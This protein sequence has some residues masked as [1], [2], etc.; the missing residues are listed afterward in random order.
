M[1]KLSQIS[2]FVL[3]LGSTAFAQLTGTKTIPGSYPTLE[4]A[5]AALNANGVG[6]GGVTFSVAA[7]Y[8]ETFTSLSSG[9][10]AT[11]T[12]SAASPIVFTRSSGT[13]PNPLITAAEGTVSPAEYVICL[14][15][16]DYVTIDGIDVTDAT[17]TVE[18]GYALLKTSANDGA[19]HN[20]IRNCNITMVKD[21]MASA[22]IFSGNFTPDD[23]ATPL[24]I[25]KLPGTNSGNRFYGNT[26]SNCYN[27]IVI[28]GYEDLVPPYGLYDQDN[29]IGTDGANFISNFGG[30]SDANNGIYTAF[31]N[32]Q[33][34]ANNSIS[35]PSEGSG[36]CAGIQV[37]TANDA[38]LDLYNNTISIEY[39]GTGAFYGIRDVHGNTYSGQTV[40]NVYNNTVSNCS[41][42]TAV[43]ASC[44]YLYL[45]GGGATCNV[46]DNIVTNNIYG[47][48]TGAAGSLYGI[49]F[50]GDQDN[51]GNVL[52]RANQ[53]T[54]I[55]RAQISPAGG[56][57]VYMWV[58]GG[59]SQSDISN[60]TVD[61]NIVAS[62][63]SC[64]G[65]YILNNPTGPKKVY[66]NT[67]TNLFDAN[68]SVVYG[69]YTGNGF[70][71]SVYNNKIQNINASGLSSVVYGLDL[72][73][74]SVGSLFDM[75]CY[76]N[77]VG[78][79]KSTAVTGT[80]SIYGI[81][82]LATN[83]RN[84]GVYNN[85][86]FLNASSSGST[87]GTVGLY[88]S[89]NP[90]FLELKNNVVVNNSDAAGSG[91]T[92]ALAFQSSDLANY[93]FT[94]NNN[95][96]YAGTPGPQHVICMSGS[97]TDQTLASFKTRV[98]PRESLSVTENPPFVKV[99]TSPMDLHITATIPTQIESA[100]VPVTMPDIRTDFD[101]DARYPNGGYPVNP[102]Y[103]ATAPDLGADEF[104]GIPLDRT[105]PVIS[106]TPLMNTSSLVSRT[107]TA[108]ITDANGVPV[109]GTGVPRLAWKKSVNGTWTYV[110]GTSLGG[111]QYNFSF[112]GGAAMNDT[113]FYYVIAQDNWSV[114]NV[115]TFPMIGSAG[116]T[117]SPPACATPPL[118]PGRY[119]IIQGICGTFTVGNGQTYPTLTAAIND[120]GSRELTCPV[121]LLLTDNN[122]PSET[123]PIVIN[124]IAGATSINTLTIRP[125]QGKTPV[126]STSYQG[127]SPNYFSM[128]TLNGARWVILD[129][130]NSGGS[131]RSMTFKN[132]GSVGYAAAIGMYND[133]TGGASNIV[134]KNCVLRA[135]VGSP[136]N[137]Q[138]INLYSITGN[139]GFDNI[140]IDNNAINSANYPVNITG[141]P[142][143]KA[144]NCQVIN[145][146]IGSMIDTMRVSHDGI[147]LMNCNNTLVRGNE[148]IG[149]ANGANVTGG[150]F[151][152]FVYTGATNTKVRNNIVHDWYQTGTDP[153]S[154]S[155]LG[156][157]YSN[158]ATSL[159][160]ISNNAIYN[161]KS[162]SFDQSVTGPNPWG[163]YV[164]RGGNLQIFHNS[165]YMGGAYL[166]S[167]VDG[168]SGCLGIG[169]N[170]TNVDI[171]DNILKNS[172]QPASGSPGT[173]SYAVTV[174][175][176]PS[177]V[178]FDYN[179]YFVDGIGPNI[180]YYG[181]LDKVTL[182]D[183]QS[184]IS[185]D[186]ST[187]SINPLF[188]SGTNLKPTTTAMI[189]SGLYISTCPADILGVV[190]TNPPDVGAYEYSV[191]PVVATTAA[192]GIVSNGATLNGTIN[193]ENLTVASF[194]DY[195]PTTAYGTSVAG[196]PVTVTGTSTTHVSKPV[197]SLALNTIYHFRA[198]GVTSGGVIYYGADMTFTTPATLPAEITVVNTISNDTCFN[199]TQ[200][201]TVAG[202]PQTFVV[203]PTGNV[204][205]IAGQNIIFLPGTTVH[206]GGYLHG[207]ITSTNTYCGVTDSPD[208]AVK[209]GMAGTPFNSSQPL[210]RVYP[211]PTTGVFTFELQDVTWTGTARVEIFGMQG[212]KFLSTEV[213]GNGK[214]ELSLSGKPAGI[215]LIRIRAGS[216]T[217]SVRII[218]Q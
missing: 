142:I 19:Q 134:V 23:P 88:L 39:N 30:S 49:Y 43:T 115:G 159:T 180:G 36:T 67:V 95:D 21:N 189:R 41:Y 69:I 118:T 165:V 103:P 89:S 200:T 183:W 145:N 10:I 18:W 182:A 143:S 20:T 216:K 4:A 9:M 27:G 22:G 191:N 76:N 5:I 196:I 64:Y 210:F 188:T 194:F 156:I 3:L 209:S 144:T 55:T 79:L 68:G 178:T 92:T 176:N 84:L 212:D 185:Q 187:I 203:T 28:T 59:G 138:G 33:K 170:I 45:N 157:Y 166:S 179:D 24:N 6:S 53:V 75:Y 158:D 140:I 26:I 152:I 181:G 147:I 31:Q 127:V 113:I 139:A 168:I 207:S 149:P 73:S 65:M 171:K 211:N 162:P 124:P 108:S 141:T 167:N 117:S 62:S 54:N 199:A 40:M 91:F 90:H 206:F 42:A 201:I 150:C 107:L 122:Y 137:T 105:P 153:Q 151:G 81:Y 17:A 14:R 99:A 205:M 58:N 190:R 173:K 217:E 116:F 48:A 174:G 120:V 169:N 172:S 202:T 34:I 7:G 215:Y 132:N 111:N 155:S 195:G 77:F 25:T 163:I 154:G 214:Y 128:I 66:N 1:K 125:A 208:A 177:N 35:G 129:G 98:L 186:A 126:F 109:S 50:N 119:K 110:T 70:N 57:T 184:A 136:Y 38:G 71:T 164:G 37:G 161:I 104:G 146:T 94:S 101:N 60:N 78:D 130:S 148:I 97:N 46:H 15:G 204:T 13:G 83:V 44:F 112:G 198:R 93:A 47:G 193:A 61:N 197:A 56:T 87:F 135:N 114:P 2:I 123:Y 63:G 160:E 131:D 11:T 218:K 86:V 82:G 102:S 72:S 80:V 52:F 29:E 32:N 121:T 16:A 213:A 96:Y 106:Y 74:V 8:T 175:T 100:G 133:G 85:T 12:G 51:T 192:T